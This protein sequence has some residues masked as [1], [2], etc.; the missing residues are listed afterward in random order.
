MPP[1]YFMIPLRILLTVNVV[2]LTSVFDMVESESFTVGKIAG[3]DSEL[4][5]VQR[6]RGRDQDKSEL[7]DNLQLRQF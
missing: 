2:Q 1:T 5:Q 7:K 6:L 4:S 3:V